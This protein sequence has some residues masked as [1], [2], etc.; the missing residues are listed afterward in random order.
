MSGMKGSV[1]PV[2]PEGKDVFSLLPVGGFLKQ[3]L[4]DYPGRVSAVIY[5]RGCNFRCV[6][7]HNPELV[8][9]EQLSRSEPVDNEK[10]FAWLSL[11]RVL[12]DAVVFTGGEPSLHRLLPECIMKIKALGLEVKLDTNGTNPAMLKLLLTEKL[13][14]YVAMDIKAALDCRK[15][16]MICGRHCDGTMLEDI[17]RSL[18]LLHNAAVPCEVRMTLLRPYHAMDDVVELARLVRVPFFLQ[19]CRLGKTLQACAGKAF[20][21]EEISRMVDGSEPNGGNV[22]SR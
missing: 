16:S 20:T 19:E 7:C 13:V 15:Y 2:V 21:K 22:C 6:Y 9:P 3:S 12:L 4:N 8:L 18:E 1:A 14:D 5:T 17:R 10:L 11:N